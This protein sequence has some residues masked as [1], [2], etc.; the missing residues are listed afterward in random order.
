MNKMPTDSPADSTTGGVAQPQAV[1]AAAVKKNASGALAALALV[2]A[3]AAAGFAGLQWYQERG[4]EDA[5]RRELARRL[6]DMEARGR[7]AELRVA[8]AAA[9]LKEAEIKLGV[10]EAKLAES[11]SQQIA[12]EAL[13]QELSRNR[14]DWAFAEIEQSVL[15]AS[16][17]LQIAAN[18]RAALIGLENA[19]AR[20]QRMD[21][22]R[23]GVLRLALSRDIE[24]LKGL[25]AV[26]VP[27]ISTRL[28]GVLAA[29]DT[30]PLAM[31][32]RVAP[33]TGSQQSPAVPLPAWERMLREAWQEL[34]QLIRVQRTDHEDAALLAPEQAFFLRENLKLRL[35]GA[36]IALLSRDVKSYESNMRAALAALPRY[37]AKNDAAVKAVIVELRGLQET[38]VQVDVPDLEA[39]LDALRKLR[40]ARAKSPG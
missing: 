1:P 22:P 16:Q 7:D 24:R 11:Q 33:A 21:Q 29:I 35:L 36:R 4:A 19:E 31:E 6:A 30:L 18:V 5:L 17:Q 12:L 25:P 40:P 34:R 2:V 27:G 8:Q 32:A 39:T 20:L 15:L 14:D 13:Y 9:A 26:D 37:F 23:Y 28:D 38:R 3:L 10:L